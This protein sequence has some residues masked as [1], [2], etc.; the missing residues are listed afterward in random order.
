MRLRKPGAQIVFAAATFAIALVYG[1]GAPGLFELILTVL[2]LVLLGYLIECGLLPHTY[3][4]F[5]QIDVFAL[6]V[7]AACLVA[8]LAAAMGILVAGAH[9]DVMI[10]LAVTMIVLLCGGMFFLAKGTLHGRRN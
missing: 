9:R 8:A 7:S 3:W 1:M 4:P 5:G 2:Y 6:A 10:G